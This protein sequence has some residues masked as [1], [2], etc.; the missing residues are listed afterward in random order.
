MEKKTII[1]L[2]IETFSGD[3]K[4]DL[5]TIKVPASYKKDEAILK[6]RIENQ[7]REWRKE[8]LQP[9]KGKI[10]CTGLAINDE[11]PYIINGTEEE[12]ILELDKVIAKTKGLFEVV[13]FNGKGFDYN[14]LAFRAFKFEA[15]TISGFLRGLTRYDERWKDLAETVKFFD[16]KVYYK[17]DDICKYFG[18]KSP[19]T[20]LSGDKVFDYYLDGKM[21]EIEEYCLDDVRALRELYYKLF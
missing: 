15:K 13:A 5:D 6:Y 3:K 7:E 20:K 2:D 10:I 18:I 12:I 1:F 17:F 16:Y 8:S 9:L 4:P 19:K 11:D 14:W 21:D